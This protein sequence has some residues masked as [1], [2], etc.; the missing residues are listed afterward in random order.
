MIYFIYNFPMLLEAAFPLGSF[1]SSM[2]SFAYHPMLWVGCPTPDQSLENRQ[3]E[4]VLQPYNWLFS[5]SLMGEEPVSVPRRGCIG[6]ETSVLHLEFR[7]LLLKKWDI[8]HQ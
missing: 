3:E 5:S 6:A 7:K 8:W 2:S 4:A 1:P